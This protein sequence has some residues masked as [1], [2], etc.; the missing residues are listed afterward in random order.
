MTNITISNC[1][2][3]NFLSGERY[4]LVATG[5][6]HNTHLFVNRSHKPF[7]VFYCDSHSYHIKAVK[8]IE[9]IMAKH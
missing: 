5:M 3:I 8:R 9:D 1:I 2:A 6:C 4:L 7:L